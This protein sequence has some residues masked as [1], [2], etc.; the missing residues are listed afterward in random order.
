[1]HR[2]GGRG[3]GARRRGGG[4]RSPRAARAAR[5]QRDSNQ[6]GDGTHGAHGR[7]VG[8]SPGRSSSGPNCPNLPTEAVLAHDLGSAA[9]PPPIHQWHEYDTTPTTWGTSTVTGRCARTRNPLHRTQG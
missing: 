5:Q 1:G 6:K 3:G 2:R 8:H 4:R 7:K 9:V